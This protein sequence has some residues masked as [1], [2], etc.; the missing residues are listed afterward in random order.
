[1]T[2]LASDSYD[3]V[4]GTTKLVAAPFALSF[5]YSDDTPARTADVFRHDIFEL[6]DTTR[7]KQLRKG[8]SGEVCLAMLLS[9]RVISSP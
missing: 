4:V 6:V 9:G 8:E 7:L 3:V 2:L 1:M 5:E